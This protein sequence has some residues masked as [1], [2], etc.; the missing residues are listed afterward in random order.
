MNSGG[1]DIRAELL[2]EHSKVQ[3][4][5]ICEY[6]GQDVKRY[7][8]LMDLFFSNEHLVS[9]RAAWVMRIVARR[10]SFLFAPYIEKATA[11]LHQPQLHDAVIRNILRLFSEIPLPESVQGELVDICLSNI[12]HAKQPGAIKAFSI[13]VLQQLC[14]LYPELAAEVSPLLKE[15]MA[16]ETP[17][18]KVRAIRFLKDFPY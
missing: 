13:T 6:I 1:M 4:L 16:Y 15:R 18:F 12:Q 14:H 8:L 10:H 2:R 7:G 9:Q 17:A 11:H 3:T 5:R